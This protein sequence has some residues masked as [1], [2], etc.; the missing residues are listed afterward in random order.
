VKFR[1]L[2]NEEGQY[3]VQLKTGFSGM[4]LADALRDY[5]TAITIH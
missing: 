3:K 4:T 2:K 5:C 1:I